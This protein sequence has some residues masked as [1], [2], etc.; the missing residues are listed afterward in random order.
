MTA[1]ASE[2][3]L[4]PCPW[5][6]AP[7]RFI[8]IPDGDSVL[9]S[10]WYIGCE[11]HYETWAPTKDEAI[12]AWNTRA[13]VVADEAMVERCAKTAYDAAFHRDPA[14]STWHLLDADAHGRWLYVARQTL[15]AMQG[16]KP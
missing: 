11:D 4:K 9:S 16:G 6:S 8:H 10:G 2:V 15:A 1:G 3:V 5:C 7:I 14:R 12:A 13:P